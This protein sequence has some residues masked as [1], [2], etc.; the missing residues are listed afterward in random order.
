M[1]KYKMH[2][3]IENLHILRIELR[4]PTNQ[5]KNK[6]TLGGH[7]E[8]DD[9]ANIQFHVGCSPDEFGHVVGSGNFG[10]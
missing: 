3:I 7:S 1:D 10:R 6:I 4:E 5:L 9:K 2:P 8:F